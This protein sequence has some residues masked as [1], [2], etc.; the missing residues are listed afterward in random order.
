LT[1][2]PLE[3]M[4]SLAIAMLCSSGLW[5][6]RQLGQRAKRLSTMASSP[7]RKHSV[8]T[9]RTVAR[10]LALVSTLVIPF[11]LFPFFLLISAPLARLTC[12][13]DTPALVAALSEAPAGGA[14]GRRDH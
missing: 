6:R 5:K 3:G 13:R 9:R 12:W 2:A 8:L 4:R 1:S 10:A 7:G 14:L 11:S